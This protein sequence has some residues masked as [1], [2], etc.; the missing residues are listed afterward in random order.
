MSSKP[1]KKLSTLLTV[2]FAVSP[3]SHCGTNEVLDVDTA[4]AP[5]LQQTAP[6]VGDAGRIYQQDNKE[7]PMT[8]V[9]NINYSQG[10]G[11]WTGMWSLNY[12][13]INTAFIRWKCLPP[14]TQ[15]LVLW[16]KKFLLS[17]LLPKVCSLPIH[18]DN[19]WIIWTPSR[20]FAFVA[21]R[22]FNT[23]VITVYIT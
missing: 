14:L 8:N 1:P 20:T 16:S 23:S 21:G 13:I 4:T 17:Q 2:V 7:R 19:S 5:H 18:A 9:N 3:R 12:H 10:L 6:F 22:W 11:M 15:K